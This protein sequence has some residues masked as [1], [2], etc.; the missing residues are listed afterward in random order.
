MTTT[1]TDAPVAPDAVT[2]DLDAVTPRMLIDFK[3]VTGVSLL[4]LE[5]G[6]DG[7]D[8]TALG[9]EVIAGVVWLA[10][11]MS[12]RAEATYDDALDTPFT[13]LTSAIP[14]EVDPTPAG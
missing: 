3:R 12:G 9:E 10:L 1:P 4:E 13:I 7:I 14:D 8:L 5:W 6:E 2:F 11:R